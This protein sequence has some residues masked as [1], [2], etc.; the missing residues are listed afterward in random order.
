MPGQEAGSGSAP[1]Y[2]WYADGK[3]RTASAGTFEDHNPYNGEVH[4]LAPR[5]GR[6]ETAEAIAAAQRAFPEWARTTPGE[7][8]GYLRAAAAVVERRKKEL[9]AALARETGA[10]APNANFQIGLLRDLMTQVAAW[11]YLPNGELLPSDLPGVRNHV[12]RRPLGVVANIMPWNG[13]ATLSWRAALAPLITG[14]TVVI[15]PSEL[16]PL[17]AGLLIAEVVD[18]AGFPPG[19]VNVVTHAPGEAGPVADEFFDNPN[20]RCINFVGSV[21]TGRHLAERAGAAL[22]R[23]VLELGGYNP[24]IVMDDVDVEYAARVATFSAFFHQGQICMNTRK[25]IVHRDVY[26]DFTARL[27]DEAARL[28]QGDPLDPKTFVGP[29][30]T[31]QALATVDGRVREAVAMGAKVLTGGTHEGQVYAPTVLVDVPASATVDHEETFGPVVV[32]Q[33]VDSEE[34]A[35]AVANST[36]YGLVASVLSGDPDRAARIGSQLR[37]GY[38]RV[39]APSVG[40]EIHLPLG[41][42]RDSGWGRTGPELISEFTDLIVVTVQTGKPEILLS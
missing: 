20:V 3:W 42:V 40:E 4:A 33:P 22:K 14:N 25:L 36:E 2:G 10:S 21:A 15:K 35:L 5:C 9:V 32:V 27:V 41:G 1:E 30:I 29:L 37:A 24:M 17:S 11:G 8:A 31:P 26:K 12:E 6:S 16:A 28:T 7:R 38:V 19:V 39:N 23:S 13:A 18:E 34:E